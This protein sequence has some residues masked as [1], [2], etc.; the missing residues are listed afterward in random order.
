MKLDFEKILRIAFKLARLGWM[1]RGE[2]A[3]F[4]SD[5]SLETFAAIIRKFQEFHGLEQTG[6][7][8]QPTLRQI[9]APRFCGLPDIMPETMDLQKWPDPN[10]RWAITNNWPISRAVVKDAISFAW[11]QW[12]AVCGVNPVYVDDPSQAHV[13]VQSSPI[14]G[15]MGV[16]AQSEL[17][18]NTMN[19]KR[20][21]Y[22]NG[23][24]WVVSE[25]PAAS[26]IDLV[27]VACHE[28]GHVLGL[29]HIAAGNLLQP[30]YDVRIRAPQRGDI[31]EVV[32]RYGPPRNPAPAP[33][34][35]PVPPAP[36][37]QPGA[38]KWLVSSA[39]AIT[40]TKLP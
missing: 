27:R 12:A 3:A 40:F 22:D 25:A 1:G 8:D 38:E 7:L 31:A 35:T 39:A 32:A 13:L 30:T 34:T 23:E 37:P 18:N 26:Q 33:P 10:I 4:A 20:Q 28:I 17:A 2:I 29:P 11:A 5:P 6:Q 16:L 36:T 14:D 15:P 24:P 19:P 9:D 21:W